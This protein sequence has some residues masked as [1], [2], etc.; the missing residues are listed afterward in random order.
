[1]VYKGY[2]PGQ[3]LIVVK[4]IDRISEGEEEFWAHMTTI[5][6]IYHLNLV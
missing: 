2:L 6:R 1:M 5:C 4:R 3:T